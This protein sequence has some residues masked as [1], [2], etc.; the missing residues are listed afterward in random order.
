MPRPPLAALR[1][2]FGCRSLWSLRQVLLSPLL[3]VSNPSLLSPLERGGERWGIMRRFRP[4]PFPLR[5]GAAFM[6]PSSGLQM[7]LVRPW[8]AG[9]KAALFPL[10]RSMLPAPERLAAFIPPTSLTRLKQPNA[11]SPQNRS[12]LQPLTSYLRPILGFRWLRFM[13]AV[14]S[15]CLG[16]RGGMCP[17]GQQGKPEANYS[18]I[19][20][21]K[22][23]ALGCTHWSRKLY[24]QHL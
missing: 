7:A 15:G 18:L 14:C 23:R 11:N 9:M 24:T 3:S 6:P 16:E 5:K 1:G 17:G 20:T 4:A 12:R 2:R 19:D 13:C 8:L 22:S 21:A 10:L